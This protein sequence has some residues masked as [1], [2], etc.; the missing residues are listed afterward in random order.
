V[1]KNLE[2][3][4]AIQLQINVPF[5]PLR[6]SLKVK[7]CNHINIIALGLSIEWITYWGGQILF[8]NFK[9][10]IKGFVQ[11]WPI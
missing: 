2:C 10:G 8:E 4:S 7:N 5:Q 6:T 1:K 9:K 3:F 11:H